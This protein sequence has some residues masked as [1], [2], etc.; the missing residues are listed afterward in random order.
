MPTL[1]IQDFIINAHGT[2]FLASTLPGLVQ[3]I[4]CEYGQRKYNDGINSMVSRVFKKETKEFP[5]A[6]GWVYCD[7]K[8]HHTKDPAPFGEVEEYRKECAKRIHDA[9]LAGEISSGGGGKKLS[10]TDRVIRGILESKYRATTTM[11]NNDIRT[12]AAKGLDGYF[13][14]LSEHDMDYVEAD[15]RKAFGSLVKK[16]LAETF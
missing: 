9:W 7:E 11:Q 4:L 16:R 14:Y 5:S 8:G 10:E 13:K 6:T 2:S 15:I 12:Q 1:K 3:N